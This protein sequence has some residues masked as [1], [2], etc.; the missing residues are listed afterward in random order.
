M[1]WLDALARIEN[2]EVRLVCPLTVEKWR[3]DS[4]WTVPKTSALKIYE[5]SEFQDAALNDE[6]GQNS[7]H[8]FSGFGFYD[9]LKKPYKEAVR[10][11]LRMG[12][13]VERPYDT[14]AFSNML[15]WLR[16]R[17]VALR[18]AGRIE[19]LIALGGGAKEYYA[20]VGFPQGK[21]LE[22]GYYPE[23]QPVGGSGERS[24]DSPFEVLVVAGLVPWKRV[25]LA[26]SAVAALNGDVHLTIIG[27]GHLEKKLKALSRK[28]KFAHP[29]T[30]IDQLPNV[31]VRRKM[32]DSDV[33]VLPSSY[34]GWGAVVNEALGEGTPVV[35]SSG[36]GACVLKQFNLPVSVFA[37]NNTSELIHLLGIETAKGVQ[38]NEVRAKRQSAAISALSP[39]AA[40]Q[41]L[42]SNL[43]VPHIGS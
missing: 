5:L 11:G 27:K 36:C 42:V 20:G 12:V 26:I 43:S 3:S 17:Y 9:V 34:D 6:F 18:M 35:V 29:V 21:I 24:S 1:P 28:L 23:I 10:R 19:N 15:R 7:L 31:E 38:T 4:G 40:A 30:W 32:A 14:N 22:F 25:D 41:R 33:L 37:K 13:I 8:V 2:T 16:Y 39:A